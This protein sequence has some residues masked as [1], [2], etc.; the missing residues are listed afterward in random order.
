MNSENN[1]ILDVQNVELT[2]IGIIY[3]NQ[4]TNPRE[5]AGKQEKR[6]QKERE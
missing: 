1:I 6:E 2:P 4:R 3:R 5:P